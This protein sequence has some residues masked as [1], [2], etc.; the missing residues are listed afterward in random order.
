VQITAKDSY[1]K[2]VLGE[3]GSGDAARRSCCTEVRQTNDD[4]VRSRSRSSGSKQ[5]RPLGPPVD[6][7]EEV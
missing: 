2:V 7:G 1:A 5:L 6:D 3:L 4:E